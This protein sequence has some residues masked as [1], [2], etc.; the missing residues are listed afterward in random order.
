MSLEVGGQEAFPQS[1]GLDRNEIKAR[2]DKMTGHTR[3]IAE[4]MIVEY[5]Q[6]AL[7]TGHAGDFIIVAIIT[8]GCGRVS[9]T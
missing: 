8:K 9:T 6:S 3:D 5:R 2:D 4:L 1:S 7:E